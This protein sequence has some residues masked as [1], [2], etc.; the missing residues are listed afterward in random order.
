MADGAWVVIR[1]AAKEEHD[2]V[3]HI[4]AGV[5]VDSL[6]G[7]DD[8][9]TD[10]DDLTLKVGRGGIKNREVV[11]TQLRCDQLVRCAGANDRVG[12]DE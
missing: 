2:T 10:E 12:F 4:D 11:S 3:L 8:A 1:F 5:I 7:I 6:S 9:V